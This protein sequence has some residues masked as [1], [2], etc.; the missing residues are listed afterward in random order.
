MKLISK[1]L[2]VFFC[3][4]IIGCASRSD[5]PNQPELNFFKGVWVPFIEDLRD[6]VNE[7]NGL[8]M[9]GVNIVA[10]GVELCNNGELV[11][12]CYDD[13]EIINAIK[14]FHNNGLRTYLLLN[15]AHPYLHNVT[16][17]KITP[18]VLKWAV[19]CEEQGVYMFSPLNEPQ[20]IAS[21]REVSEW[22]Q[23]IIRS[24]RQLYEGVVSFRVHHTDKDFPIYN[25]SDYD[26]VVF[27]G[28]AGTIDVTEL[29]EHFRLIIQENLDKYDDYY[30]NTN[31]LL[32]D[33]G[34]FTG[35]D[36]YWWEPI[37]PENVKKSM[38][39][40]NSDF[41]LLSEEQQM[42][43]YETLFN[44]TWSSVNGYFIPIYK[45]WGYRGKLAEQVIRNWF[46]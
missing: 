4:V 31:Y 32:F 28:L 13:E 21:D 3:L 5:E 26:F 7:T 37:A 10:V 40:M 29:P 34:G 17:S 20:L 33:M 43:F 36:Y 11:I 39:E 46:N 18:L 12:E 22:A 24:I 1:P 16:L 35:P 25:L 38:P 41:W 23:S 2:L 6:A 19:I 42:V 44:L 30:P 14:I 45:G 9:D 15:P 8:I 27:S